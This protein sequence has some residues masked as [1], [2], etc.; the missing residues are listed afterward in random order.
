M[1]GL[2]SGGGL[3]VHGRGYGFAADHVRAMRIV[4]PDGKIRILSPNRDPELFWAVRGGKSNFGP[5]LEA[6]ID[7]F[8]LKAIVGGQLTFPGV[9][10]EQVLRAWHDWNQDLPT[11]P[12]ALRGQHL[13]KIRIAHTGAA[14]SAEKLFKPLRALR[15]VQDDVTQ[16]PFA[17]VAQIAMDSP[18]PVPAIDQTGLIH[19]LHH[20]DLDTILSV[21]GP[22]QPTA[23]LTVELRHLG[24][25]LAAKPGH[26]NSLGPVREAG[27]TFWLVD[28]MAGPEISASHAAIMKTVAPVLTGG[29]FPNFLSLADVTPEAVRSCYASGDVDP[30][31]LFRV[32][33]NIAPA[34]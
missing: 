8:P 22:D 29:R 1:L 32:N 2:I 19:K 21:V 34:R 23:P 12:E 33:H 5:L 26:A 14:A 27:F 10:G 15:P 28:L 18:T 11:V 31:N 4:T 25:K 17:D 20:K 24:G 3:P 7:L 6:T 13:V 9:L 16:R 30:D